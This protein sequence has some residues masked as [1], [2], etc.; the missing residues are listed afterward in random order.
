MA[1][2]RVEAR[3]RRR[4]TDEVRRLAITAGQELI[5]DRKRAVTVALTVAVVLVAFWHWG[6]GAAVFLGLLASFVFVF[7]KNL[8]TVNPTGFAIVKWAGAS[9]AVY[10]ISRN[11]KKHATSTHW[12]LLMPK[13]ATST[14]RLSGN[15]RLCT[16]LKMRHCRTCPSCVLDLLC[17]SN[18]SLIL[19]R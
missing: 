14:L 17:I 2:P 16:C 19:I 13:P 11:G 6:A 8:A 18:I 7:G 9:A 3:G 1:R 4:S 12:R 5:G 15:S 10:A